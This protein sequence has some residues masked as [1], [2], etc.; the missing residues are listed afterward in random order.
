MLYYG[1]YRPVLQN[2]VVRFF[3]EILLIKKPFYRLAE[4]KKALKKV[5]V[6]YAL[7]IFFRCMVCDTSACL[8]LRNSIYFIPYSW[9]V[10]LM[11]LLMA[12]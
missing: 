5:N 9:Q 6:F 1:Y 8:I 7:P 10:A 2:P 3:Y 12:G 4:N 11:I